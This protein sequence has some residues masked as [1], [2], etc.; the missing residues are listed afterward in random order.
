MDDINEAVRNAALRMDEALAFIRKFS[1]RD[2]VQVDAAGLSLVL[3]ALASTWPQPEGAP[4]EITKEMVEATYK[5]GF[6]A[7]VRAVEDYDNMVSPSDP[8]E[9]PATRMERVVDD[10]LNCDGDHHARWHL[11]QVAD[12]LG[13]P[14]DERRGIAP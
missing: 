14:V 4:Q 11:E 1:N 7:G 5:R 10:G 13:V 3:E 6:D 8:K 2:R 12:L 9:R